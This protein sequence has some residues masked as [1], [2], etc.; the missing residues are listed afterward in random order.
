MSARTLRCSR[1]LGLAL[2]AWG[3]SFCAFA[4]FTGTVV[5]INGPSLIT[6]KRN[7]GEQV[8]VALHSIAGPAQDNIYRPA[9]LTYLTRL[10][11]GKEA[12]VLERAMWEGRIIGK[13]YCD[14]VDAAREM[15]RAGFARVSAR[16]VAD[17][18]VALFGDE[19]EAR[20]AAVGLWADPHPNRKRPAADGSTPSCHGLEIPGC[21]LNF[22]VR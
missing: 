16:S 5:T 9:A 11:T 6:V 15:V 18:D 1:R 7:T 22:S 19:R 13:V 14:E 21:L 4:D 8:L 17:T 10:C 12:R 3:A 20:S 2:L